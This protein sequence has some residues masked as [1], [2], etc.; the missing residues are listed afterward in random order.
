MKKNDELCLKKKH[1]LFLV[2]MLIHLLRTGRLCWQYHKACGVMRK[3]SADQ[4][5][6]IV[7][8]DSDR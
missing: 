2:K 8:A 3:G 1:V 5:Y 6:V 7:R 4:H